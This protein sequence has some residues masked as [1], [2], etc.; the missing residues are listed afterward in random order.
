M[1]YS[2]VTQPLVV[3]LRNGGCRSSMLTAQRTDVLPRLIR[4]EPSANARYP[5]WM[6][7]GRNA[8]LT[9][10]SDRWLPIQSRG[11]YHRLHICESRE[12]VNSGGD[13]SSFADVSHNLRNGG[14]FRPFVLVDIAE[15]IAGFVDVLNDLIIVKVVRIA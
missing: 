6:L 4:A 2:A 10:P 5:T 14:L 12:K 13:L 7:K 15:V 11:V 8:S 9:R 1:E 3:P